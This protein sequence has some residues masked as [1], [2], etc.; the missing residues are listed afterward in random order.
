VSEATHFKCDLCGGHFPKEPGWTDEK[1]LAES[2]ATFGGLPSPEE[3]RVICDDCWREFLPW[4]RDE[5]L[6]VENGA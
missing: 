5:G 4:A 3:R 1:A 6:T 2:K